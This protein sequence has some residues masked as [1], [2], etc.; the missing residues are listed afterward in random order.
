MVNP[1]FKKFEF[2]VEGTDRFHLITTSGRLLDFS[3]S[4]MTAGY[5]FFKEMPIYPVS[6]LV[7]EN[8]F[9]REL[10]SRLKKI[11]GFEAVAFTNSGTG[12]CDTAL[13][14]FGPPF[15]ALEGAYHGRTYL[16]FKVSNGT[17]W[18][19]EDKIGHLKPHTGKGD[20]QEIVSYNEALLERASADADLTGSP[21]IIELIQSDGGV[22]EL[23]KPFLDHVKKLV[24]KFKLTLIVDEVY[25]GFGR[26]GELI[27]SQKM[28][29]KADMICFGKGVAAGLP[30]GITLYNGAWGLPYGSVLAMTGGNSLSSAI[31]LKVMDALTDERL[32]FVRSKGSEIIERISEIRNGAISEVRGRG[33]M[34]GVDLSG[35]GGD[36]SYAYKVRNELYGK[37]IL[38]SLVGEKNNVLKV[39]PPPLI[40]PD[41]LEHGIGSII[42]TLKNT[43]A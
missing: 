12:A 27:L 16:T 4:G 39:T 14:R 26:S 15:F 3:G 19:S 6:S 38:C 13:S 22:V 40:E 20:I 1:E 9:S 11:S 31:C 7:F 17:G 34:I 33:F 2:E 29:L 10:I 41:L 24:E 23:S 43:H 28:D 30:L 5:N 32:E 25:T 21:L 18:S 42:E 36:S 35:N 37:G 8:K